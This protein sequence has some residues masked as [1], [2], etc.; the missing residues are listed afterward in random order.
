MKEKITWFENIDEWKP[1]VD[2]FNIEEAEG[3]PPVILK[4]MGSVGEGK[5]YQFAFDT[6]TTMDE[7][8]SK[9]F[10]RYWIDLFRDGLEAVKEK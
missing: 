10:N 5:K 6:E 3:Q 9:R 7:E 1:I 8:Q 4:R 2:R